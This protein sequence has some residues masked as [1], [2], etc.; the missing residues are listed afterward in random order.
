[1]SQ[2]PG[3]VECYSGGEYA[4]RPRAFYWQG[5]RL[6]VAEVLES[7]RTPAGKRF[8]VRVGDGSIFELSYD[9]AIDAWD[10]DQK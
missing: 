2:A 9:A 4:E 8:R 6:E 7:W 3:Q 5:A 10:I 1:M